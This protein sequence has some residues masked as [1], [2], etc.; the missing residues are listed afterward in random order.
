MVAHILLL[1]EKPQNII[2]V[3]Q[4]LPEC[5]FDCVSSIEEAIELV[6]QKDYDLII[7]AVHL[8]HDGSVFDFLKGVKGDPNTSTIPFVFYCSQTSTFAR[9]VRDGLQIA[10][11]ALGAEKYITMEKFEVHELRYELLEYLHWL[12]PDISEEKADPVTS[13]S[14]WSATSGRYRKSQ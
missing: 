11:K 4:A 2:N 12:T 1:Q 8:E 13:T 3:K 10:A 14:E 6:R 9:S 7:S 5:Q